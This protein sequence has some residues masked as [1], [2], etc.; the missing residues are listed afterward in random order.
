MSSIESELSLGE[1]ANHFLAD[2]PPRERG[3]H[4]P[5]IYKFVRWFG[6]ERPFVGLTAAEVANY[7]AGT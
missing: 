1:A 3:S 6:W 7:A 4:Q 5:E 2:L